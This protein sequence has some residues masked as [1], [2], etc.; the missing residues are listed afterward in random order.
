MKKNRKAEALAALLT[1][2]TQKDA[3]KKAGITERTL[4]SY[5][6]DPDFRK[7]Y[8][9]E[10][11]KITQSASVKLRKYMSEAVDVLHNMATEES[12][13]AT[14]KVTAARALL[15]YGLKVAEMEDLRDKLEELEER[16]G[17]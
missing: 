2:K 17:Q 13:G 5:L 6:A 14:A 10:L 9:A 1:E 3:A 15:D 4:S 16:I 11:Q 8:E 7:Q 12:T